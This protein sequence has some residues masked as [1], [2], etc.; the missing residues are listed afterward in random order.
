M[1]KKKIKKRAF[2]IVE[3]VVV[4]AIIAILAAVLI[5]TFVNLVKRA[6]EANAL[7]EAKNLI[8]EMLAEMLLGKEGDADLLVFSQKGNDVYA[9]GYDASAGRILAYK[10]NPVPVKSGTFADFVGKGKENSG[11]DTPLLALMLKNGEIE[12][13]TAVN[14]TEGSTDW[15]TPA[16]VE[17]IVDSLNTKYNMIVFANYLITENFAKK[18]SG[19]EEAHVHSWADGWAHNETHHWHNCT[20]GGCDITDNSKK[21][22]YEAHVYDDNEDTTCNVCGYVRTVTPGHTHEYSTSWSVDGENHWHE[23]KICGA[24]NDQSAHEWSNGWDPRPAKKP[25]CTEKGNIECW[26]CGICRKGFAKNEQGQLIEISENDIP[27]LGHT[28][29]EEWSFDPVYHW[30]ACKRENCDAR[31]QLSTHNYVNGVCVCGLKEDAVFSVYNGDTVTLRVGQKIKIKY[32]DLP[33]VFWSPV[34]SGNGEFS[35]YNG[36]TEFITAFIKVTNINAKENTAT[37]EALASGTQTVYAVSEYEPDRIYSTHFTMSVVQTVATET[38]NPD[39]Y[40]VNVLGYAT[41]ISHLVFGQYSKYESDVVGAPKCTMDLAKSGSIKAYKVGNTLYILSDSATQH[42]PSSVRSLTS[43][44]YNVQVIDLGNLAFENS[45]SAGDFQEMFSGQYDA[46]LKSLT[47]I[48]VT[49]EQA[50]YMQNKNIENIKMFS[51]DEKLVGGNGTKWDEHGGVQGSFNGVKGRFAKI[52]TAGSP[53]YFT[54]RAS[55]PY[56]KG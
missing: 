44:F 19:G 18:E 14:M 41:K 45:T 47:T 27:A 43:K 11:G 46:G 17:K 9:Y 30:K 10:G 55:S 16:E 7:L 29:E 5:P 40:D 24:R 49:Q 28:F 6:N 39:F 35:S 38:I 13:N 53:G 21:N 25:T 52:D 31:D 36:K 51:G 34:P 4:I 50:D 33:S 48:Y 3:L 54:N 37:I 8:T 56:N 26:Y 20:A 2:T 22:G 1:T 23:C 32:Q 15:R 42:A 12:V